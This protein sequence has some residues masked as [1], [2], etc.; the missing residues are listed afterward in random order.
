M[1]TCDDRP[2]L[3]LIRRRAAAAPLRGSSWVGHRA[4][5]ISGR[6]QPYD[7]DRWRWRRMG[8]KGKGRW[9]KCEGPRV[10]GSELRRRRRWGANPGVRRN[11]SE[12][13]APGMVIARG[14]QGGRPGHLRS[15]AHITEPQLRRPPLTSSLGSGRRPARASGWHSMRAIF[16][17]GQ[18]VT[19]CAHVLV[20]DPNRVEEYTSRVSSNTISLCRGAGPLVGSTSKNMLAL[21]FLC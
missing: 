9:G 15:P 13:I 7:S 3:R 5:S 14:P 18:P 20:G 4:S 21:P 2:W 17:L 1:I 8:P 12:P 10:E 19:V 6:Y 16:D 11:K